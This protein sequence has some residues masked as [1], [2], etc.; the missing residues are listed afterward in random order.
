MGERTLLDAILEAN[1]AAARGEPSAA[2]LPPGAMPFVITCMDPRLVGNLIPALGLGASPP[3]QAKF[4]GGVVRPGEVAGPRSVLAAAI[5][6]MATEVL[7]VG[8]TDCRMGKTSSMEVRSGLARLGVRP[9]AFG[10][11]DPPRWLGAFTS[12]RQAVASSVA[13]LRAD[14]RFPP[15]LPVHG[16]LFNLETRRVEVVLRGYEASAAAAAPSASAVAPGGGY[17]PGPASLEAPPPP[18][19][20]AGPI[21]FGAGPVSFGSPAPSLG[22]AAAPPLGGSAPGFPAP[23]PPPSFPEPPS[24]APGGATEGKPSFVPPAPPPPAPPEETEEE[25]PPQPPEPRRRTK[26]PK[27]PRRKPGSDSPFDRAKETLDRL[28]RDKGR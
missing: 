6:N 7:I 27:P 5:F 22:S 21:S 12:E 19:L 24:F 1:A 25:E 2:A 26:P 4:A 15:R 8:H 3:P 13:A 17:A 14:P 18:T 16:L 20:G 28:R 11:E 9:E 23:P 10:A